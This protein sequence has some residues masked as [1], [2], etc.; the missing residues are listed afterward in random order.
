MCSSRLCR[1]RRCVP[2]SLIEYKLKLLKE[3][4]CNAYRSA[5]HPPTPELL[6]I[7]DRL[8]MMVM[9]EN[10]KLDSSPNGLSQLKRLLYRDRN[11]PCVIIWSMENEEILEGTA[12]GARI[13]K[14]LVDTTRRIDPTRPTL[15]A[16]NHGWNEGGYSDVA[17]ITGYNYGQRE[18]QDVRDHEAFPNRLILGSESA[19]F[20]VTR[21]IY[22]D[23]PEK[24]YCSMYGTNIPEWSCSPEKAW[25][26]VVKHPFLTGVF[27]WTGFDYR[28]EPTPYLWPCINSH[29]GL[30]DTCG[31]P[32]DVYYYMKAVWK[33][34]PL[35]HLYPHW[36]WSGSEGEPIE[37][38]IFSNT[39]SVEL[40]LNGKKL[41]EAPVD[42]TGHLSWT[43]PYEPGEIS[44]VGK[45]DGKVIA[46]Q[47]VVTAGQPHRIELY[48]DR[49][50]MAADGADTI[51]IRVAVLD[52]EGHVI[53]IADNEIRFIVEGAG[54]LLGVGNGDP[55]SH[56]SDKATFRRCFNGWCLSL[57]QSMGNAGVILVK[58][59]SN[60]LI[61]AE[62][63]LWAE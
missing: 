46:E 61:G 37:V 19:S 5:H 28:G 36:N 40:W 29:F 13:L 44:A 56:E 24:G 57:V 45:R 33:D 11:H 55:S 21:G 54:H 22:E 10:R 58:A 27:M 6:D 35:V 12:M 8:G 48:P 32:K 20:T 59:V 49:N 60:G 9:D 53:P 42:R 30:M 62:V 14:T 34:E 50:L 18:D 38:R 23:D 1:R 26:D 47:H 17:D 43:V 63:E 15:A 3:M 51:P 7:C 2:D 52:K 31:F 25:D 4:G 41:G 39:E 16:M